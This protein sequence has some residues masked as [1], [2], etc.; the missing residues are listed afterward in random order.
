MAAVGS[1]CVWLT[2]VRQAEALCA[3]VKALVV[4]RS[5]GRRTVGAVTTQTKTTVPLSNMA[6]SKYG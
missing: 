5:S 6:V 1:Q 3:R 4:A 2:V